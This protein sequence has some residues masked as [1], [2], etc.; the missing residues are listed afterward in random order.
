[1]CIRDRVKSSSDTMTSDGR[2]LVTTSQSVGN[3]NLQY[4]N[5]G[6]TQGS[7]YQYSNGDINSYS[8]TRAVWYND[9]ATVGAAAQGNSAVLSTIGSDGLFLVDQN[10][11]L[12]HI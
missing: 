11:S 5:S 3:S 8:A 1:M 7:V 2:G 12:I 6:Y 4:N 9:S 10:L